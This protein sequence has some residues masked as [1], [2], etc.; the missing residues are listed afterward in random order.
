MRLIPD[1]QGFGSFQFIEASNRIGGRCLLRILVPMHNNFREASLP[2]QSPRIHDREDG[3]DDNATEGHAARLR[4]G[5]RQPRE[6]SATRYCKPSFRGSQP[7]FSPPR[8]SPAVQFQHRP[9]RS[10]CRCR[11]ISTPAPQPT[12]FRMRRTDPAPVPASRAASG[13][14]APVQRDMAQGGGACP[15]AARNG[16]VGNVQV[17]SAQRLSS[18]ACCHRDRLRLSS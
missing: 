15:R 13:T 18:V 3:P 14:A 10:R 7:G 4:D 1:D 8:R 5:F 12:S 17:L 6:L 11:A 9:D 2:P 16:L